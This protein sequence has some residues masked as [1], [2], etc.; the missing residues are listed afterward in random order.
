MTCLPSSL[1]SAD[2]SKASLHL[3]WY[4]VALMSDMDS[5]LIWKGII[6]AEEY[7][8]VLEQHM[9]P[10]FLSE[11]ALYISARPCQINYCIHHNSMASQEKSLG[12]ELA[13]LQYIWCII[14]LKIWQRR[15]RT[16]EQLESCIR[17]KWDISLLKLQQLVFLPLRHLQ[18]L[19]EEGML[20]SDEHHPVP[21]FLRFAADIKVKMS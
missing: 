18:L 19:K 21:A 15:L 2:S 20:L 16:V 6:N 10:M 7:I 13:Y 5:L 4:G 1:L 11:K 8:K 12:V 14:K 17:R 3:W 9:L